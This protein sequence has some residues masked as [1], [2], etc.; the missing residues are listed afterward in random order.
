MFATSL[1]VP[2]AC[3]DSPG[4]T[5]SFDRTLTGQCLR[6]DDL[7]HGPARDCAAD[8]MCPCGAFCHPARHVCSFTCK[9]PPADPA[10]RCPTGMSCND[11]G[12]CV[13]R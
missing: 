8:S 10:Q 1:L 2:A 9:V 7:L 13:A 11:D 5:K 3:G 4:W 6:G 12:R